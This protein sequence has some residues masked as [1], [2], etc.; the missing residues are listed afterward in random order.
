VIDQ[1]QWLVDVGI[2][3]NKLA[4]AAAAATHAS[5]SKAQ[6]SAV[7]GEI[8]KRSEMQIMGLTLGLHISAFEVEMWHYFF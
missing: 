1:S 5:W 3:N 8:K 2:V 6:V 4:A 7:Q